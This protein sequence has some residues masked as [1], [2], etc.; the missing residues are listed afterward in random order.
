[1]LQPQNQR[2]VSVETEIIIFAG[3]HVKPGTSI[4]FQSVSCTCIGFMNMLPY[5]SFVIVNSGP[6]VKLSKME[7]LG[8]VPLLLLE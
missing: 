7:N 2:K 1:M 5:I 3:E 8:K 4:L 6:T